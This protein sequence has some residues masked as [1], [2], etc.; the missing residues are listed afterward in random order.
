MENNC[1]DYYCYGNIT[2]W[3]KNAINYEIMKTIDFCSF[4]EKNNLIFNEKICINIWKELR[5]AW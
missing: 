3:K 2:I 5:V 1:K 4:N